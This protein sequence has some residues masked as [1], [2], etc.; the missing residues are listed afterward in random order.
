MIT[1]ADE[2]T[3]Y[4]R[5]ALILHGLALTDAQ[6]VA[7]TQQ[8]TLLAGMADLLKTEPLPAG[9]EPAPVFRL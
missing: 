9:S 6:R 1:S 8:F 5:Q 2:C 4:V 3:E 7:V